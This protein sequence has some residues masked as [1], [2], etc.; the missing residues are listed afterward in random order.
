MKTAAGFAT[1]AGACALVS[2]TV[3]AP[4]SADP[5]ATPTRPS[6]QGREAVLP[7]DAALDAW[8][9]LRWGNGADDE[10]EAGSPAGPPQSR[11]AVSRGSAPT[12]VRSEARR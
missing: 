5:T 3:V 11:P 7:D 12:L 1:T 2:L 6:L 8:F 9:A 10:P 4:A